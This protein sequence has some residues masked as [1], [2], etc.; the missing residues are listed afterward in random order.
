[1]LVML[2]LLSA[3]LA[4]SVLHVVHPR[5]LV[6]P[7]VIVPET[8][9]LDEVTAPEKAV[10]SVPVRLEISKLS[11]DV[12]VIAAGLTRDNVMDI[13]DDA[14]KTAWYKLGPKPGEQGS[15]VIAGHY[16]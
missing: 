11:V 7:K 9:R 3:C 5:N 2:S 13:G 16:G 10:Y 6:A 15:A 1:M 8:S 12:P 14:V 4:L